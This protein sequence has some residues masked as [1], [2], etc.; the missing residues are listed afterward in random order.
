LRSAIGRALGPD[1]GK[2]DILD[3]GCGT[4]LCGPVFR[5]IADHLSG[6][7]ISSG[8]L[9]KAEEKNVYDTLR[10]VELVNFL[11]G[12]TENFDLALAADVFIYISDLRPAFEACAGALK[13]EGLF[14]FSI[15]F[16]PGDGYILRP[17][18]R[19]GHSLK[20]IRSQA[21]MAGFSVF[22]CDEIILRMEHD[23]PVPGHLFV[24]SKGDREIS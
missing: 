11:Q 15:E 19:F 18:G 22:Q 1:S 14:A 9:G 23:E 20:Y 8:M 3:L 7:D 16:F 5:D 13:E 10:R 2:I 21:E 4:G 12:E 17:S 24:L 6:V